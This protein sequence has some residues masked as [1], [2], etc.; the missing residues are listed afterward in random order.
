MSKNVGDQFN[1]EH[2]RA[3]FRRKV[4]TCKNSQ[5][6]RLRTLRATHADEV[7]I[8]NSHDPVD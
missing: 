2:F 7:T 1:N 8:F 6:E 3:M 4:F 5:S